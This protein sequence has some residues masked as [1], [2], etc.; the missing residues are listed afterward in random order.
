MLLR[1]TGHYLFEHTVRNLHSAGVVD[2]ILLAT[3]SEEIESAAAELSI[4][5]VMTD[6]AH[7]SGTDRVH[8]AYGLLR[9]ASGN[10]Y[11]VILNVQGDEPELS[12]PDLQRLIDAFA[13]PAV[14]FATLWVPIET[15]EEA[16][17]SSAVKVVLDQAGDALY[18][19]RSLIPNGDHHRDGPNAPIEYKRHIGVY[20]F[21][22]NALE[23]FCELPP[24]ALERTENLEQLRWLESGCRLRV[25]QAT[26]A[27]RGIDTREDYLA[28]VSRQAAAH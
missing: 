19:S 22:P 20:A 5:A 1:E 18:F 17:S 14:E 15:A 13:D 8:E 27:P 2:R 9:R 3:D 11:D 21:R 4:E 12:P 28:F 7:T 10:E 24:S 23:R 26:E 25:L 6:A 16:Q